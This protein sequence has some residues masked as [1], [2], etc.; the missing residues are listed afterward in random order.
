MLK[1]STMQRARD[2]CRKFGMGASALFLLTVAG[3]TP[4]WATDNRAPDVPEDLVVE[5]G[6]KVHFHVYAAGYQVYKWSA[7]T[8]A[9]VFQAPEAVLFNG[10]GGVVGLHYAG[11][12]WE[13]NSGSKVVGKRLKGVTVDA[14]AI[15]WLLLEATSSEGPGIFARTSFVQRVNT[16][17]GM[18]PAEPGV[19]DGD[20]AAVPYTAEYYFY[21][22]EH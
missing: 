20:E 12:T 4:A 14:D 19:S 2:W 22:E 11:P 6:N 9:W 15:P 21:R 10:D 7:A 1:I 13:S 8:S 5:V 3:A 16:V 18:P 17:G